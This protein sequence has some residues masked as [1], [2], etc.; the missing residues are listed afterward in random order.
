MK[1]LETTASGLVGVG[2]TVLGPIIAAKTDDQSTMI[3]NALQLA[4]VPTGGAALSP[5]EHA[6]L[7]A[8]IDGFKAAA[9]RIGIQIA[10]AGVTAPAQAA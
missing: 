4:G 8:V 6:A 5:A 10:T 3:L 7:D 1:D 2:K 9:S